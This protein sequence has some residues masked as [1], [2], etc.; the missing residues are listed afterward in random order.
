MPKVTDDAKKAVINGIKNTKPVKRTIASLKEL[1]PKSALIG[2][3]LA[4]A[5]RDKR[6]RG[7]LKLG[8]GFS[9][10][11]DISKDEKKVSLHYNT[12]F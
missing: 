10:K 3:A 4:K 6:I 5:A 9:L 7:K 2:V 1:A 8:K 12:S 11:G